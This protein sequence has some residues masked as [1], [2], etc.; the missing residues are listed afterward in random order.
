[1]FLLGSVVLWIEVELL[2]LSPALAFLIQGVIS[3]ETSFFL[4]WRVT[5]R[6]RSAGF[7]PAFS[8]F[9]LVKLV[10]IPLNQ[11]VFML[12]IAVGAHYLAANVTTVAIFTLV[13]Y[14]ACHLWAFRLSG[15]TVE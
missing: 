11:V 2:G 12:L 6:A 3:V 7:W 9:N 8:R 1:V 15:S 13:N 5:W 10:T 4:N 14:A